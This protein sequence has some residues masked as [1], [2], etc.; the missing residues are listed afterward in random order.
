MDFCELFCNFVALM[1]G[2]ILYTTKFG[3]RALAIL[4]LLCFVYVTI[5]PL[6]HSHTCVEHYEETTEEEENAFSAV[7]KVCDYF[8][9]HQGKEF[10]LLYPPTIASILPAPIEYNGPVCAGIYE[11]TLNAFT[12]KG[13]PVL[14]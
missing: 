3:N 1:R 10:D 4:L 9:Q 5:L 7:C 8:V 12:N 2:V 14:L 11:M 6:I 13:P